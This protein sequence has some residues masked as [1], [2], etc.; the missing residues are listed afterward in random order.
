MP[1]LESEFSRQHPE[2]G[3]R[4]R[5][6]DHHIKGLLSYAYPAVREHRLAELRELMAY[7]A[8]GIYLDVARTHTGARPAQ[9]R[10]VPGLIPCSHARRGV[11]AASLLRLP[12]RHRQ[13]C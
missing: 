8:D 9:A 11:D 1:G 4:H 6:Y 5:T 13:Y 10:G 12:A 7:G 3:W 2:Y